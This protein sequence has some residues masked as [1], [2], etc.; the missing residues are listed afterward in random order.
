MQAIT[1]CRV[2]E[3]MGHKT[4]APWRPKTWFF[5]RAYPRARARRGVQ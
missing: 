4:F 2:C 1:I 5:L 3:V